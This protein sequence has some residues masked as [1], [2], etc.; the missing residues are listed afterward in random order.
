MSMCMY[1]LSLTQNTASPIENNCIDT[2][3]KGGGG[4]DWEIGIGIYTLT[5][6]IKSVTDEPYRIAQGTQCPVMT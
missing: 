6:Y 2:K 5:L 1:D 3:G 4:M